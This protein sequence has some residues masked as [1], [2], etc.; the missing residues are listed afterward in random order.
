L[1]AR[2]KEGVGHQNVGGKKQGP[3][4]TAFV[5]QQRKNLNLEDGL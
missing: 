3:Q 5:H 4:E 2:K 1:A